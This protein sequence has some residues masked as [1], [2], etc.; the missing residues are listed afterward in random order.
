MK[1]QTLARASNAIRRRLKQFGRDSRANVVMIFALSLIPIFTVAGFAID[2]NRHV[3]A[4]YKLQTALD[5]AALATAKRMSEEDLTDAEVDQAAREFFASQ[6]VTMGGLVLDPIDAEEV[7]PELI[8]KAKGTLGTSLM[9]ITGKTTLP[10]SATTAVVY[11][12]QQ[13]VELALVVDM[14]GSMDGAKLLALKNA[15]YSL[16][17]ILLP[18]PTNPA[19]NDAAKVAVV[20]F[21]DYVKIDPLYKSASWMR[22]TAS[23]TRTWESCKTTNQ[24]RID[25]GCERKTVSCTKWR[26]SV[27]QGNRESYPSTC[28]RWVCPDGAEPEQTCTPKSEYRQ[29][30]GCVR[31]RSNP[32]NVNDESYTGTN[33]VRGI[34]AKNACG[35]TQTLELSNNHA[36]V[37][38]VITSLSASGSTYIPAGLIWGLRAVSPNAPLDEGDG[39]SAFAAIQGRKAIMLMSDGANT[40]S[41]N[42]N[43]YH[44]KSNVSQANGYTADIC[45]EA[46]SLGIEVYTIA[47]DLDDAATKTMLKT[48]ATDDSYYYDADDADELEQAFSSIGRELSELAIAK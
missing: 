34:V 22:N 47:F 5:L 6:F 28:R 35:V 11:N 25:A 31:S 39:Y 48:C 30:H 17:D 41:P 4:Q 15:S 9:A 27:E 33:R 43:G 24:A 29:F 14:S 45:T 10:L 16:I 44:N 38:S 3:T 36:T 12:I 2:H 7:G 23:Y 8:L 32:Y 42:N 19:S 40:V 46:K 1:N 37:D 18:N 21:N 20:P 26:G 13:P